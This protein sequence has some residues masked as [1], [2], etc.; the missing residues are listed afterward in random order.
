M[1]I[2]RCIL[3]AEA[4]HPVELFIQKAAAHGLRFIAG[5]VAPLRLPRKPRRNDAGK[6]CTGRAYDDF[7]PDL[8]SLPTG[9]AGSSNRINPPERHSTSDLLVNSTREGRLEK[10]AF[11]APVP[12]R[13]GHRPPSTSLPLS[14]IWGLLE[15]EVHI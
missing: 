15:P 14:W 13:I 7:S 2:G 5:C 1:F 9:I 6:G 8:T 4:P 12:L 10:L 3:R 11:P